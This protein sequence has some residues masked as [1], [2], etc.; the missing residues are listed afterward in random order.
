MLL[1]EFF[2]EDGLYIMM[3]GYYL[4]IVYGVYEFLNGDIVE[5]GKMELDVIII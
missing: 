3:G 5:V 2:G 1:F 4:V